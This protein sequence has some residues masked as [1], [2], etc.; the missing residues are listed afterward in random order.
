MLIEGGPM[1][2]VPLGVEQLLHCQAATTFGDCGNAIEIL[3]G[4]GGIE[5]RTQHT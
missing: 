1:N 4:G 3:H 2:R 5:L